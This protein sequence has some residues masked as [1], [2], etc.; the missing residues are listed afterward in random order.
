MT[1]VFTYS[2]QFLRISTI[3]IYYSQKVPQP[4]VMISI[5]S[6]QKGFTIV[7]IIIVIIVIG[8]LAGLVMN[9]VNSV[10]V[11]ARNTQRT[12]T[13]KKYM[14]ALALYVA[15][16]D[17]Y[18]AI[19]TGNTVCLGENYADVSGNSIG[20]CRYLSGTSSEVDSAFNDQLRT[21]FGEELVDVSNVAV[22]HNP[23]GGAFL[24]AVYSNNSAL[25]V[26]GESRPHHIFFLLEGE[27]QDCTVGNALSGSW[28]NL[29]VSSTGYN[30][31]N[32]GATACTISL[33]NPA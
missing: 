32:N 33:P 9:M 3:G 10:Q 5:K 26:A 16:N 31:S 20:D 11:R 12:D 21:Y 28:P 17:A 29:T 18:P 23:S 6:K 7:E 15:E 24:G 8:V 14:T 25:M 19:T 1:G 13:V 27:Q 2:T 30:W 4:T 22:T